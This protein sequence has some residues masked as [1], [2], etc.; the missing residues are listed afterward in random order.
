MLVTLVGACA[1]EEPA[2]P[3]STAVVY[4]G[5][6]LIVGDLGDPI[7][8]S[9]IV[10]DN[11]VFTLVGPRAAVTIPAGATTVDLAGQTVM[12]AI[13]DTHKHV[14]QDLETLTGQ[15]EHFAYYGIGLVASLGQDTEIVLNARGERFPNAARVLSAGRGITRPEPGRSEVPYW[16]DTEEDARTAVQALAA[17]NV[18]IVKVWVDDRNGQYPKV[19]PD[20]YG[21]IIEEAHANGL[22]VTA[23]IFALEDAKGLLEA[24]ID[25]FAHGVRDRDIDDAFAAMLADH[26]DLVLIPNM[27][28][29]GVAVDLGW[30]A[31]TVPADELAQMQANSTDRP[32]AQETWGIQARNLDR[33]NQAGTMIAVG[34]DGATPW[35]AHL[36]MEDMVAAGMTPAEVL[37]AATSAGAALYGLDEVGTVAA[38]NSA[39]FIVLDA[40]PLDDIT[41]TRLIDAVYL[42][43]SMVDRAALAA[44]WVE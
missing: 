41:N 44:Q 36:E 35:A 16:V 39:D 21:P 11:G 32:Q 18:D 10:V 3:P 17:A 22:K 2:P 6:R 42:R 25:S 14:A 37:V 43:G 12:P 13:I 27:P 33:M 19:G 24:G 5:A 4:E 26:P 34:T 38:G 1:T 15:L 20:L 23:H 40:N 9:I 8:D 29:R 28:D 31:G 7:E 30:L